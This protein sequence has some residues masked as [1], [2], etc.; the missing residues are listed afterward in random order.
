MRVKF[1]AFVLLTVMISA[2]VSVFLPSDLG[3]SA[4]GYST[5]QLPSSAHLLGTDSSG[6]DLFF[7]LIKGS[8]TSVILSLSTL[9]LCF[10]VIFLLC[11]MISVSPKRLQDFAF[12]LLD[13]LIAFP[14]LIIAMLLSA[15]FGGSLQA[16]VIS[17]SIAYSVNTV[18]ILSN[19]IRKILATDYVLSAVTIGESK[20]AI[21]IRHV[22]PSL[23]SLLI[24][25]LSYAAS[26]VLLAE[27]GLTY[28]GYGAPQNT[29]SWGH[30]L[31][32]SA[33][34]IRTAPITLLFP[35]L[36]IMLTVLSINVLGDW[37]SRRVIG[38]E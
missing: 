32:D 2:V 19:E 29:A 31:S 8:L 4:D 34:F 17:C 7:A 9:S 25:Q 21:F 27:A 28:L 20:S 6:H 12:A 3:F 38:A 33:S 22:F 37:W 15:V 10:V 13:T 18:R 30:V 26:S 35:G 36:L 14:T 5:L 24:V 23:L 16:V 11:M 1:S